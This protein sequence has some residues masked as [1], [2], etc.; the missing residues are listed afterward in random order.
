MLGKV[1]LNQL[2]NDTWQRNRD[3]DLVEFL[4]DKKG[5]RINP[6]SEKKEVVL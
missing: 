6:Y 3:I 2:I 5:S 4:E 1:M